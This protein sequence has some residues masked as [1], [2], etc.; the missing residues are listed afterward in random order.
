MAYLLTD[1]PPAL[2][3][4]KVNPSLIGSGGSKGEFGLSDKKKKIKGKGGSSCHQCKSRRNDSAL[5]YCTSNLDKKNKRCRKKFCGHCLKKFYKETPQGI[6]DRTT[7]KC[8]SCRKICCCAACRRRKQRDSGGFIPPATTKPKT[9]KKS[10]SSNS[11]SNS[12]SSQNNKN[13][14]NNHNYHNNDHLNDPCEFLPSSAPS[15]YDQKPN[16]NNQNLHGF[17]HLQ[18]Q[19]Y[20]ST[21]SAVPPQRPDELDYSPYQG[22]SM[23]HD[24]HSVNMHNYSPVMVPTELS[25]PIATPLQQA[26][27]FSDFPGMSLSQ[28]IAHDQH[29]EKSQEYPSSLLEREIQKQAK[30]ASQDKNNNQFAH[31]YGVAQTPQV[32]TQIHSILSRTDISQDQKVEDIA[33]LLRVHGTGNRTVSN[34]P[35][36]NQHL[37]HNPQLYGQ[38]HMNM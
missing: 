17:A 10:S 12:N 24:F 30:Q 35:R 29:Q 11:N 21:S 32:R 3:R 34:Q 25:S 19:N 5:T 20:L 38:H 27:A 1:S 15:E 8:P 33:Q 7:W 16:Q 23:R 6:P 4:F 14:N 2:K 28:D 26:V 31:L 9:S 36:S 13:N 18:Q 37:M 22:S